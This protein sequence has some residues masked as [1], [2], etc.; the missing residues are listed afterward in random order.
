MKIRFRRSSTLRIHSVRTCGIMPTW[1][2]TS[3]PSAVENDSR[4]QVRVCWSAKNLVAYALLNNSPHEDTL[5][6]SQK[7]GKR[8][9]S[10]GEGAGILFEGRSR[11]TE[12]EWSAVWISLCQVTKIPGVTTSFPP[13]N[14]DHV[15]HMHIKWDARALRDTTRSGR[16]SARRNAVHLLSSGS[17]V[18]PCR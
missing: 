9:S 8:K 15:P 7:V 2:T 11:G 16:C 5:G 4:A 3:S 14:R 13:G 12:Q 6:R 1:A 17:T 10:D 18:K